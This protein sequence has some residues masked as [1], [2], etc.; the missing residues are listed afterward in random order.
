MGKVGQLV[1]GE[2]KKM[3]EL[4]W[5]SGGSGRG[6]ATLIKELYLKSHLELFIYKRA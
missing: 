4:L 1:F 3:L 5:H 6:G 2:K